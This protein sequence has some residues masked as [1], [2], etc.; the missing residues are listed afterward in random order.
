M[1]TKISQFI[2]DQTAYQTAIESGLDTLQTLAADLQGDVKALSDQ[3]AALQ[4]SP[5]EFNAEDQKAIDALQARTTAAQAKFTTL[6][7]ALQTLDD[8]TPPAA[9]PAV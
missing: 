6:N 5:G 7:T 2:T 9:P 8:L 3:I 4:A 1:A